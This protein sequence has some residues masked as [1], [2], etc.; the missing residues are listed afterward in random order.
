MD[1]WSWMCPLRS[2]LHVDINIMTADLGLNCF[3]RGH[4]SSLDS[5]VHRFLQTGSRTCC[6]WSIHLKLGCVVHSSLWA[7]LS[8]KKCLAWW[9]QSAQPSLSLLA[10]P[11]FNTELLTTGF[12]CCP[13]LS[14]NSRDWCEW[15]CRRSEVWKSETKAWHRQSSSSQNCWDHH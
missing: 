11:L 13:S 5:L 3:C 6:C 14:K 8:C 1:P 9:P 10:W 15:K 7:Q 2:A 12:C 4:S